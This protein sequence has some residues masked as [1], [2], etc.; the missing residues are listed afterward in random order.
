VSKQR[1]YS[2]MTRARISDAWKSIANTAE[3]QLVLA[4]LMVWCNAYAPIE[5]ND[6]IEMARHVGEN[7]VVK[8]VAGFLGYR[9]EE[10]A[11]KADED[12]ELLNRMVASFRSGQAAH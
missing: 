5:S 12:I 3:G 6:P 9:P 1:N 10:F 8:R 7:N 2:A 4:D 11:V